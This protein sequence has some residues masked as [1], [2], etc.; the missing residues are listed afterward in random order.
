MHNNCNMCGNSLV[1]EEHGTELYGLNNCSITGG[2]YS[3]YLVDLHKYNFNLCESCLRTMFNDFKIKPNVQSINFPNLSDPEFSSISWQADQELYEYN[4]WVRKDGKH[5]AYLEGRC[6]LIKD[7]AN[8]AIYSLFFYN[9]FSEEACCEKHK[10]LA[11]VYTDLVGF[12]SN[13]L[14]PFL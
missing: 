7:C 11:P 9:E 12:V 1:N 6:N 2:Y 14:K 4:E 13:D 5:L 8:K 3:T 10:D